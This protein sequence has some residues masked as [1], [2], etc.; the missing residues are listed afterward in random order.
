[1]RD[2]S[3]AQLEAAKADLPDVAYR[4]ALHVVG[5]ITRV[6]EG[7]AA[8]GRGDVTTFGGFMFD[9]QRSSSCHFEN[10]C[11]ELDALVDIAR[12]LPGAIGARLSGGGF[13][14]ITVHLVKADTAD[15]VQGTGIPFTSFDTLAFK[16]ERDVIE[17][18]AVTET[19]VILEDHPA[20]RARF[21]NG[22]SLN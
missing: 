11:P 15:P 9:S 20:V 6:T 8:L 3:L 17:H 2:V 1:M 14:G 16:A 5:E 7:V 12:R 13:G 21:G 22:C 10:S 4:R 18:G 19:C